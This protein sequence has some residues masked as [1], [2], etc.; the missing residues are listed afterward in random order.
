MYKLLWSQKLVKNKDKSDEI[1]TLA[2]ET[3]RVIE[4]VL[5]LVIDAVVD[6]KEDQP[7]VQ[8][9]EKT[10]YSIEGKKIPAIPTSTY[11]IC[12]TNCK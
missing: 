1:Q 2:Q 12:L 9:E 8:E 6:T 11:I 3:L 10:E 7:I 4:A 5:C